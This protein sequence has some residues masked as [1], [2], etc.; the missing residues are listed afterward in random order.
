MAILAGQKVL[1]SH[2]CPPPVNSS[3]C[4]Y[5][6]TPVL[7]TYMGA[8]SELRPSCTTSTLR[9]E[10]FPQ[11]QSNDFF[12]FFSYVGVII[13]GCNSSS[14]AATPH[15]PSHGAGAFDKIYRGPNCYCSTFYFS[16]LLFLRAP[17]SWG[18]ED[19]INNGAILH[20]RFPHSVTAVTWSLTG[21]GRVTSVLFSADVKW[22]SKWFRR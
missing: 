20:P 8:G 12:I 13:L 18:E 10:P 7:Q 4:G 22:E 21:S 11:S 6:H 15:A 5:R 3:R 9:S 14:P 19:R 2:L 1:D 16:P 17:G